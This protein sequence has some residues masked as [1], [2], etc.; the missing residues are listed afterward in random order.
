MNEG[1]KIDAITS[2][3]GLQQ[4]I[5]QPTHLLENSSS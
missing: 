5:S 4:L 1:T 3:C 2:S